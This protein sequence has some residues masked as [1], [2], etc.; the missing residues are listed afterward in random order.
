[1]GGEDIE[2]L[3][4]SSTA[5]RHSGDTGV[6]ARVLGRVRSFTAERDR[7]HS[8]PVDVFAAN[9]SPASTWSR[10]QTSGYDP[11]WRTATMTDDKYFM[12]DEEYGELQRKYGGGYV[13][14]RGAQVIA[15]AKRFGDLIDQT[16][17]MGIDRT[18]W[19]IQYI[20]RA[21]VFRVY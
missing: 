8:L 16:D 4:W 19:V 2:R 11:N 18:E 20:D 14:R 1:L 6:A 21:D 7:P 12:T 5:A 3:F 15:S 13:L 9:S 10:H 17:A